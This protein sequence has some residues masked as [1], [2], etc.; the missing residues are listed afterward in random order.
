MQSSNITIL[1]VVDHQKILT[2]ILHIFIG[3]KFAASYLS[4][5][6]SLCVCLVVGGVVVHSTFKIS[7]SI[8]T[9]G[10]AGGIYQQKARDKN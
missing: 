10:K 6:E 4:L 3:K 1:N 2:F 8:V 7:T 9:T 5:F